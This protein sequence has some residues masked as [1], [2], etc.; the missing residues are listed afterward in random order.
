V[1]ALVRDLSASIREA[2]AF[3][4]TLEQG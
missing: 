1:D 4:A 2:D 3:L